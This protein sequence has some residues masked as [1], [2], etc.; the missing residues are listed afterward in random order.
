MEQVTKQVVEGSYG[1]TAERVLAIDADTGLGVLIED[2][3]CGVGSVQGE[4]YRPY[5]RTLTPAEV[6]HVRALWDK[7]WCDIYETW[8]D[9]RRLQVQV[10]RYYG[11]PLDALR[12]HVA[13]QSKRAI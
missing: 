1:M 2:S 10:H 13:R 6:V 9:P 7:P 11:N 4:C 3:W 12:R 5:L 8:P